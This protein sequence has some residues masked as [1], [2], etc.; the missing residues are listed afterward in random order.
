MS[1]SGPS[2]PL[3]SFGM[4]MCASPHYPPQ[5]RNPDAL[6]YCAL[7]EWVKISHTHTPDW[8][9]SKTTDQNSLETVILIAICRQSANKCRLPFCGR[10]MAMK[11]SVSSYCGSSLVD[12]IN[13]F[14]CHQSSVMQVTHT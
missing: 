9:L 2:G 12:S 11:S 3:V 7:R 1:S 5:N 8:P 10:Q 4:L 13:A 14:D 6:L